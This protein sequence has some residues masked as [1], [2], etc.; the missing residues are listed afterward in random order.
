M[1]EAI[2]GHQRPSEA[3]GGHQRSS[4][5][6]RGHQRPSEAI[7]GHQRPSEVIRGHPRSSEAIRG[8]SGVHQRHSARTRARGTD[9]E[10]HRRAVVQLL[11]FESLTHQRRQLRRKRRLERRM[12]LRVR[13][14]QPDEEVI[15]VL[16][17]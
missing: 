16:L 12:Q 15:S 3:I 13:S 6:I 8:P 10:L 14:V 17:G 1:S 4:E 11:R 5:A 9:R 2:R 7:R